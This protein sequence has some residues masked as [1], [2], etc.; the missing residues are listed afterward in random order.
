VTPN[1]QARFANESYLNFESFKRDGTGVRTPL[2]FVELDGKL[3]VRTP[4]DS[5][6]V[7]RVRR[8][9][10]V[11]IV[12]SSATG[13]PKGEWIEARAQVAEEPVAERVQQVMRRKYGWQK[14]LIDLGSRLRRRASV[15]LSL[16]A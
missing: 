10:R 6:K 3:Y 8:N 7:K 9:P 1:D 11:R 5:A 16:E 12:P 15:V 2:W 4:A 14:A 13:K